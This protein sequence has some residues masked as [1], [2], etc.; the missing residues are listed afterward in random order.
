[1]SNQQILQNKKY[2]SCIDACFECA[3][4]C[5]LCTTSC[6]KEQDVKMLIQCIH[7]TGIVLPFV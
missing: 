3:E 5:D 4:S 2:Q 7:L 6:L 1:M